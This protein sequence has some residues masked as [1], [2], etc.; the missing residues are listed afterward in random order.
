MCTTFEPWSDEGRRRVDGYADIRH[1]LC[2]CRKPE[3]VADVIPGA[4]GAKL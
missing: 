3:A 2:G 4:P 1:A